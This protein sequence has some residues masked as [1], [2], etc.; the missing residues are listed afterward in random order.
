MFEGVDAF[1]VISKDTDF[2][3]TV[4][5]DVKGVFAYVDANVVFHGLGHGKG[6]EGKREKEEEKERMRG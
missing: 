3:D 2:R 6:K 5:G 4:P 1:R